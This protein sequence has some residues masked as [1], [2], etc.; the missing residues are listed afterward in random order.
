MNYKLKVDKSGMGPL[1]L[2]EWIADNGD[3]SFHLENDMENNQI[4]LTTRKM[5]E[6]VE[7]EKYISLNS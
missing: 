3:I 6:M 2:L 1:L 7:C 5:S 4:T